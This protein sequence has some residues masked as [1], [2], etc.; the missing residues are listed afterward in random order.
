MGWIPILLYIHR[1]HVNIMNLHVKVI[2]SGPGVCRG[3]RW[4]PEPGLSVHMCLTTNM[5]RLERARNL[6][7]QIETERQ[8]E[9]VGLPLFLNNKVWQLEGTYK[10]Q[11]LFHFAA[12]TARVFKNIMSVHC[13]FL[14]QLSHSAKWGPKKV[15]QSACVLYNLFFQ[16]QSYSSS[17]YIVPFLRESSALRLSLWYTVIDIFS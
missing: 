10:T 4:A 13:V 17:H 3:N 7:R 1:N 9:R 12:M 15:Q 6:Y 16:M 11:S 2:L 5:R 8:K 14:P